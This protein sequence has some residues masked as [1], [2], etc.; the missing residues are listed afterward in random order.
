MGWLHVVHVAHVQLRLFSYEGFTNRAVPDLGRRLR[1]KL[2]ALNLDRL[3]LYTPNTFFKNYYNNAGFF[4]C[5]ITLIYLKKMFY[6]L[7]IECDR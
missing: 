6:V 4:S 3:I 2:V 1:R 5:L 7:L